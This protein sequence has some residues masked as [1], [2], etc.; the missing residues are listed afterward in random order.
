LTTYTTTERAARSSL[1]A[2]RLA[3]KKNASNPSLS[4]NEKREAMSGQ[5]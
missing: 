4:V 1:H 3:L 5:R 2:S